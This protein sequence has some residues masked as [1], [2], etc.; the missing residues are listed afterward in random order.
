MAIPKQENEELIGHWTLHYYAHTGDRYNGELVVSNQSLYFDVAFHIKKTS[1]KSVEGNI[2][3]AFEDIKKIEAIRNLHIF[4]RLRITLKSGATYLFDRGVMP[5][6]PIIKTLNK[7]I[8]DAA[9][10]T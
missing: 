7:A 10:T 4:R 9:I 3:I 8:K 1:V 6:E 5:V 2:M